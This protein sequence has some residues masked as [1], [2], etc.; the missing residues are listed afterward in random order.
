MCWVFL[1]MQTLDSSFCPYTALAPSA[2]RPVKQARNVWISSANLLSNSGKR[3]GPAVS[4]SCLPEFAWHWLSGADPRTAQRHSDHHHYWVH[5]STY[6][7]TRLTC[8]AMS[9]LPP[10]TIQVKRKR[11]ADADDG[12][13]DFLRSS[14]PIQN[15]PSALLLPC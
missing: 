11:G 4:P 1:S 13:V 15:P 9:L 7:T 14:R 2:S 10:E 6:A 3:S 12:P 5:A 8:L